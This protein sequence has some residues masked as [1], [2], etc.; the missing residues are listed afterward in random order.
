[1]GVVVFLVRGA[2]FSL[3]VVV[4]VVL[5]VR[6]RFLGDGETS[7]GPVEEV[8]VAGPLFELVVSLSSSVT[9]WPVFSSIILVL[10][11]GTTILS[12]LTVPAREVVR[13]GFVATTRLLAGTT[14]PSPARLV[15]DNEVVIRRVWTGM[16]LLLLLLHNLGVVLE[17]KAA[18]H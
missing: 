1:M 5:V 4:D 2:C 10:S 7:V 16:L 12:V 9:T 17:S 18:Q 6:A 15:V 11:G 3:V 8:V 13:R 14:S